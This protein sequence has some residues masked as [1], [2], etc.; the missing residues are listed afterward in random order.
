MNTAMQ[1]AIKALTADDKP[2]V[3]GEWISVPHKRARICSH[4]ECDEP[5]KFAENDVDVYNFCPNCGMPMTEE[6]LKI[7][8]RRDGERRG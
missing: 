5:Y 2:V 4:C 8:A 7:L 3:R 6:A 1:M